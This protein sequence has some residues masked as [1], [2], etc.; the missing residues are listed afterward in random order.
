MPSNLNAFPQQFQKATTVYSK[1]DIFS[2]EAKSST[3]QV[4]VQEEETRFVSML[5]HSQEKKKYFKTIANILSY[6]PIKTSHFNL[7]GTDKYKSKAMCC[8]FTP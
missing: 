2:K 7:D 8:L 3:L 6:P 5:K 4:V 1:N